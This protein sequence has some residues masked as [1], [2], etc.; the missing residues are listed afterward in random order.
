MKNHE[1]WI[2]KAQND[3]KS[4]Q[5]LVE[6]DEPIYDTSIYHTQQCAEKALKAYLAFKNQP[7]QKSHDVELLVEICSKIDKSFEKLYQYSENLNPYS[8]AFRYP[9]IYLEPDKEDVF[10]AI[11]MAKE[12]LNFIKMKIKKDN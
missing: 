5:K 7:I 4:A 12:I 1:A 2:Y 9:D 3:L 11:E 8:T 10:E 6:G